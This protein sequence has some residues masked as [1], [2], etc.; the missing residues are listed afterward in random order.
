MKQ[1]YQGCIKKINKKKD[2]KIYIRT[3]PKLGKTTNVKE[4]QTDF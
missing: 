1:F 2:Q 4:N 3:K